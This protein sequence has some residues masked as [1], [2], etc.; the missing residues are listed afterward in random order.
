[1]AD[2]ATPQETT[3]ENAV[4]T[5]VETPAD[6]PVPGDAVQVPESENPVET[7]AP[8]QEKPAAKTYDEAYVKKLREENAATRVK[9]KEAAEKAAQDAAAA[10]EKALTEKWAKALGLTK[11]DEPAD[12]AELL[13]QAEERE[14]QIAAERDAAAERLRAYERK[15]A[16][17][18]AVNDVDGDLES[19]LDSRKISV[20]IEKLDTNADDFAAQVAAIVSAAVESNP[21]LKKA[22]DRASAPRSGGDLSNGNAAPKPRGPKTVDDFRREIAERNKR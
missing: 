21:K 15:D 13:K 17:T 20:E 16:I 22:A 12:P 8:E 18:K 10:A 4:D 14:K 6:N 9:G 3:T 7:P 11:D 2:E 1:M 19:I 5:P